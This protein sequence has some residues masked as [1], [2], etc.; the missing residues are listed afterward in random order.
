MYIKT[1]RS[2][3]TFKT[4]KEFSTDNG[5]RVFIMRNHGINAPNDWFLLDG[6]WSPE[7]AKAKID[8]YCR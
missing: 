6:L 4:S 7:E 5:A 8:F 1:D 2:N 3:I